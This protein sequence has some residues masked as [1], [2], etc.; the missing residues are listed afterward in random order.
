[1]KKYYLDDVRS[2]D[3]SNEE[4]ENMKNFVKQTLDFAQPISLL[5][6]KGE[7]I[8]SV[9]ARQGSSEELLGQLVE[10]SS[11]ENPNA[12]IFAMYLFEVLSDC[13][14]TPE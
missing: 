7:I 14:L 11:N 1:M 5:R 8:S 6:R 9:A 12:R 13:H 10:W 3:M 4:L 2:K